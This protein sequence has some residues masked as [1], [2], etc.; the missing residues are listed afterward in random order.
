VK[1]VDII[2]VPLDLGAGRRGVDMGPSAFRIA[3]LAAQIQKLGYE[4]RDLGNVAVPIPESVDEQNQRARYAKEIGMVC[5]AVCGQVADSINTGRLPLCLGGDHS[6]AI[7]SISGAAQSMR[8]QKRPLSVLW[9]DAHADMNTPESSPSGN[10]HGMPLACL[11]GNGPP[12]LVEIGGF[13]PKLE[14]ARTAVVGLRNLDER[15]RER[16]RNSGVHAYT[17]KEIDRRGIAAVMDEV[18]QQLTESNAALHVS[19]DMDAVDPSF[20]PGVGTPVRGGLSYRESHLVMEMIAD[21]QRLA[22]LDVVEVNPIL[23]HLNATAALG[24]EFILSALGKNI[25]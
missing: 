4:V 10:V 23:D 19:F 15:E 13:R 1:T 6:L 24:L 11:L 5:R 8:A 14:A 16:V 18:L 3:G 21:T 12:E 7:G 20:A 2:G 17:M 22:A 25:L 9:I